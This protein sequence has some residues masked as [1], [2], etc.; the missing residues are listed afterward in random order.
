MECFLRPLLKAPYH[1]WFEFA[2]H[3]LGITNFVPILHLVVNLISLFD[4]IN[5]QMPR[6]LDDTIGCRTIRHK[7]AEGFVPVGLGFT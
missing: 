4:E 2:H 7:N 5:A 3:V 6:H 1:V